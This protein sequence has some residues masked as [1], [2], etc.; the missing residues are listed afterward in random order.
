MN[1]AE[2]I[3]ELKYMPQDAEVHFSYNYGD[4]WRT[5]VAPKVTEVFEGAVVHSEYH[6]MPKVVEFDYDDEDGDEAESNSVV[7][8]G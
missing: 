7:I 4:H 3:E 5:Q 8:L 6:R 2:L 1:V